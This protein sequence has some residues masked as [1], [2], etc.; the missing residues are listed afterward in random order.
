MEPMKPMKPMRPM[1]PVK[2]PER[3]WPEGLGEPSTAGG[4]DDVR[5][6]YFG[7]RHR[8]AVDRGGTVTVYDTAGRAITGVAQGGE[9]GPSFTGPDGDVAVADLHVAD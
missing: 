8:L 5:Y 7:D 6:A 4:Q 1:E 9:G 2:P 3:W